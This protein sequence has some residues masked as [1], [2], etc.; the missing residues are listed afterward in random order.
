LRCL[1]VAAEVICLS[2]ALES[3]A[4]LLS[5]VV[6][7]GTLNTLLHA[8]SPSIRAAAASTITKLS[9]KAKALT[10]DSA[11]VSQILN[12][13]LAVLKSANAP[14]EAQAKLDAQAGMCV[15]IELFFDFLLVLMVPALPIIGENGDHL[16]SFSAMD[17]VSHARALHKKS[18]TDKA[19]KTKASTG[20]SS[21]MVLGGGI[22]MTAVERAIESLA[23][24]VG[25]SYIK[26]EI[27]HGSYR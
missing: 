24:L 19:D 14:P 2:S 4:T 13:A 1:E 12:T 23:A 26:E 22:T 8:P 9:I 10:Q 6:A 5:S 7:S 18:E 17:E 15:D 16:V 3:G 27:V 21:A 25:K 20:S 11:E